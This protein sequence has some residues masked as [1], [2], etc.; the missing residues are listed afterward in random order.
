M[1]STT[2]QPWRLQHEPHHRLQR[3]RPHGGSGVARC[4]LAFVALARGRLQRSAARRRRR[5]RASALQRATPMAQS[6]RPAGRVAVSPHH[7]DRSRQHRDQALRPVG[8]GRRRRTSS[9]SPRRAST[10]ARPSTAWCP[11]SSSR[12]ATRKATA[13]AVPATPSP[14]SRSSATTRAGRLPWLEHPNANSAGSQFFIVLDDSVMDQLSRSY[15]IF[16]DVIVGDGCRR[17]D[18]RDAQQRSAGQ[19]R[20]Q[21]RRHELVTV[22]Q[23]TASPDAE[24]AVAGFAGLPRDS[25]NSLIAE[26]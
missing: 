5:V 11:I 14:T 15:V 17:Q 8:S 7:T 2:R 24:R 22:Q 19:R 1:P 6:C 21:P 23:P 9:T 10:T 18:R 13:P 4:V 16:G 25:C 12:A 20:H 3:H 26:Y